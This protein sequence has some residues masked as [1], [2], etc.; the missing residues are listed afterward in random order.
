ML[1]HASEASFFSVRV[2]DEVLRALQPRRKQIAVMELLWVVLSLVVWSG[3][4]KDSMLMVFEDS[5]SAE[6]GLTKGMSRHADINALPLTFWC[7]AARLHAN[8]WF[9][10]NG[11]ADNP[12]DCLTKPGLSC[13]HR[14]IAIDVKQAIDGEVIFGKPTV[15]L[16]LRAVPSW[17]TCMNFIFSGAAG[18]Q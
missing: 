14:A 12:V 7:L 13:S 3:S 10:H 5:E 4:L 9:E 8:C 16:Q 6:R 15:M 1:V 11:S 2:P 17:E 18:H